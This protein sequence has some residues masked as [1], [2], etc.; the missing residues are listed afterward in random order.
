MRLNFAAGEDVVDAD[1]GGDQMVAEQSSMAAAI[2]AFRTHDGGSL[3]TSDI[4]KC[5]H[6]LLYGSWFDLE[7]NR[8]SHRMPVS[9]TLITMYVTTGK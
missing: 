2:I 8:T 6:T 4:A 1:A 3:D 5:R 9:T 7:K